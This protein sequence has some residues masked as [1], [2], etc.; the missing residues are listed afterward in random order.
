[1][2]ESGETMLCVLLQTRSSSGVSKSGGR[3]KR[4]AELMVSLSSIVNEC[5]CRH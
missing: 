5:I 1:M 2:E 4:S 3:N